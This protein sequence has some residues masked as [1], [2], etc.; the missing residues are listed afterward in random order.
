MYACVRIRR[1]W[2]F[3]HTCFSTA[4][5]SH[6]IKLASLVCIFK[7]NFFFCFSL[8]MPRGMWDPRSAT[9]NWTCVPCIWRAESQPLDRQRYPDVYW[10]RESSLNH[11]FSLSYNILLCDKFHHSSQPASN[12]HI[13]VVSHLSLFQCAINIL[14]HMSLHAYTEHLTA[15]A[16]SRRCEQ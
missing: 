16:N 11:S 14:V 5:F 7:F 1:L 2:H 13:W 15:S 12:L 9:R 4:G 6:W 3:I 8:A 10:Y